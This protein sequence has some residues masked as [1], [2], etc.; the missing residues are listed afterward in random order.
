MEPQYIVHNGI[1]YDSSTHKFAVLYSGAYRYKWNN[2]SDIRK[3][4]FFAPLVLYLLKEGNPRKLVNKDSNGL[5]E[6]GNKIIGE[7]YNTYGGKQ[8]HFYEDVKY[9]KIK[10]ISIGK[11]IR[12]TENDGY[13]QVECY[14]D[15]EWIGVTVSCNL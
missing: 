13:E 8:Q 3:T 2:V 15:V 5:S 10:W 9:I 12:V 14:N 11:K 6:Q 1:V 7:L 4:I